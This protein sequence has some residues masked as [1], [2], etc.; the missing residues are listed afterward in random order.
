VQGGIALAIAGRPASD[1]DVK[2]RDPDL[3]ISA[4]Q[5]AAYLDDDVNPETHS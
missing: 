2:S 4:C 3:T 5:A 1:N